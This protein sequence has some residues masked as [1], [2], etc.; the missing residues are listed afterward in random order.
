MAKKAD[1]SLKQKFKLV[2]ADEVPPPPKKGDI[3]PVWGFRLDIPFYIQTQLPS[4]HY[5]DSITNR[6]TIATLNYHSLGI[7]TR[8]SSPS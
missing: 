4:K 3:D 7:K 8:T 5:V 6:N 2:Y 1:G